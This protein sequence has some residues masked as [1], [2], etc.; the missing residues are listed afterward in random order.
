MQTI[1]HRK[2]HKTAQAYRKPS[3]KIHKNKGA[4][5]G[6]ATKQQRV[7][8][9]LCKHSSSSFSL[10]LSL[11]LSHTHTAATHPLLQQCPLVLFIISIFVCKLCTYCRNASVL[12]IIQSVP[13]PFANSPYYCCLRRQQNVNTAAVFATSHL[14]HQQ[15]AALPALSFGCL[16]HPLVCRR[17]RLRQFILLL[18]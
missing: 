15:V 6:P 14:W 1:P 13:P 10:S 5:C 17:K 16:C 2:T 18:S 7:C 8:H 11:P 12:I 9:S 3:T 4:R